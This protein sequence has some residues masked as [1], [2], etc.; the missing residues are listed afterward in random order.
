M[1]QVRN[2]QGQELLGSVIDGL[3]TAPTQS[4]GDRR[5]FVLQTALADD[6]AKLGRGPDPM[7]RWLGNALAWV[8]EKAWLLA[9]NLH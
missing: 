2:A 9:R 5:Q 6:E 1:L 8:L 4:A 3:E 7:P